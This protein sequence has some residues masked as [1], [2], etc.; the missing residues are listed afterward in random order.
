MGPPFSL[1]HLRVEEG[2]RLS[3]CVVP[4]VIRV[5]LVTTGII[6]CLIQ[7]LARTAKEMR[8]LKKSFFPFA[9]GTQF[10][11]LFK[12]SDQAL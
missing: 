5:N 12:G 10:L 9:P 7:S 2:G 1:G 3:K 11:L 4:T 6:S 8:R